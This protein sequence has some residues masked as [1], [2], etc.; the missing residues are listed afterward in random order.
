LPD[1]KHIPLAAIPPD[2]REKWESR[3]DPDQTVFAGLQDAY[4]LLARLGNPL[5]ARFFGLELPD[6]KK[7]PLVARNQSI[8]AHGFS[9]V[10]EATYRQLWSAAFHLFGADESV[11]P[12]FPKL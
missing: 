6:R 9:P 4:L 7:S 8:L 11:L 1:T 12:E 3:A 5:G 10:G 2:L